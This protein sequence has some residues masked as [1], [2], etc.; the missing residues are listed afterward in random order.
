[1]CFSGWNSCAH[2]VRM[3]VR[4]IF[5]GSPAHR[6]AFAYDYCKALWAGTTTAHTCR[7][8]RF[9][10]PAVL[11]ATMEAPQQRC[12]QTTARSFGCCHAGGSRWCTLMGESTPAKRPAH[13][14]VLVLCHWIRNVNSRGALRVKLFKHLMGH[15]G[16]LKWNSGGG[17]PPPVTFKKNNNLTG[18]PI[19]DL[20]ACTR[21]YYC[22]PFT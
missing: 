20:G 21:Q 5:L 9:L 17:L 22:W 13:W 15:S 14:S 19:S 11:L 2:H 18:K 10:P 1:M 6:P 16:P 7:P 12:V 8:L 3:W 4:Q